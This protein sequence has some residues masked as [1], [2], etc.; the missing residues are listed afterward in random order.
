MSIDDAAAK[1]P[2]RERGKLRVAALLDAAAAL[3]IERGYEA[4]TTAAIAARAGASIG[5]LYQFFPSKEVMAEALFARYAERTALAVKDL[6]RRAPGRAPAQI[7]DMLVGL[8]LDRKSDPDREAVLALSDAISNIAERR[9]P[10]REAV[11]REIAALLRSANPRLT[12]R[13]AEIAAILIAHTLKTVRAVAQA[14]EE[15]RKPLIASIKRMLT[16]YIADVVEA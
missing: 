15:N 16:L 9:K 6:M 4:T 7:A 3:F 11:R 2:K 14:E 13:R 12:R 1:Q 8:M 5:S 10:L